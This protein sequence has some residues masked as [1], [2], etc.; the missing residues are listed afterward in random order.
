MSKL[1]ANQ[2]AN[3][4]D[5]GPVEVKEG[6]NIPTGKPFQVAGGAGTTGQYLKSTGSAVAWE[7][8]PTI[9]AAQ[10][11]TDWN[12][13]SGLGQI[14]NKP[15]LA[16]VATT[17]SYT[18]LTNQPTIPAGQVRSDWNA[19]SGISAI[20]N[21]PSLFDGQYTSLVGAPTVPST[22]NDL[23]DVNIPSPVDGQ[24]VMWDQATTRWIQG[25][26]SAGILNVVEDTTPQLGGTLDANGKDIDMGN[27][28]ITD[29]KVGEWDAAYS[30]GNHTAQ[31]Y[32]TTYTNT[33]YSQQ[34]VA[35]A[36]G[37]V[38]LRLVDS[39]GAQDDITISA[40]TGITL[41]Q[42]GTEGFRINSTGG[43]GGGGGA[44][45]T[46]S[47]AAP[48]T[49]T[50]GDL[51]WKSNEGRLKVYYDDGSGTQWVDA[52]PP[53]LPSFTEQLRDASGTAQLNANG[54]QFE[55]SGHIIPSADAQY[56]LGDAEHKIR[57]LFLSDNSCW[58]GDGYSRISTVRGKIKYYN[59]DVNKIP[60]K[61]AAEGITFNVAKGLIEAHLGG[62]FPGR[63]WTQISDF[64]VNHWLYVWCAHNN[65]PSGTY[66]IADMF[67][68][69]YTGGI[70]EG[71]DGWMVNPEY[72]PDDF[73]DA[74]EF[75]Q[76]GKREAPFLTD[77][78]EEY[79]LLESDTF[80]RSNVL[81]DFSVKVV[82]CLGTETNYFDMT[83]FIPQGNTPRTI[84]NLIIDGTTAT[85][86][87]ITG[88]P[89]ANTTQTF[90]INALFLG[91]EWKA[92][93]AIG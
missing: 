79:K 31:G 89:E 5:N 20:D 92:T 26:G 45:V 28:T 69:E 49:P 82:G 29:D 12:A 88:T 77:D 50:D 63:T 34:A 78:A 58:F 14:L 10:V 57:H 44:T 8:F 25:A 46:T 67:V 21:K 56:D 13:T 72:D 75:G 76:N 18:D 66:S 47:D 1:L 71:F 22:V 11:Q 2:I 17:G 48:S 81:A 23:A 39:G 83:I 87:K 53:L 38:S 91:A 84:S 73:T 54:N 90:K 62:G 41:D 36:G 74:I 7:S 30:W 64:T 32:L 16:T 15:T 51:W 61:L 70:S 55:L 27:N 33:T 59:R 3:Y 85:Q 35:S 19:T 80:I 9:P 86:V 60:S 40:G 52:S 43:G 65:V 93:V 24:Y 68:P 37:G 6:I 4:N 42:I